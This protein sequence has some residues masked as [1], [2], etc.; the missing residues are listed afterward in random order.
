MDKPTKLTYELELPVVDF[1]L[2]AIERVAIKGSQSAGLLLL[3]KKVLWDGVPEELKT[4]ET[5]PEDAEKEEEPKE[6]DEKKK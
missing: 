2:K 4:P 1:L 3:S 6:E 5:A